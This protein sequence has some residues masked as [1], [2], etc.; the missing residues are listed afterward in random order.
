MTMEHA[1]DQHLERLPISALKLNP[2]N[3]RR[4][5]K[6]QIKQLARSIKSFG[7]RV[8]IIIDAENNVLSGHGRILALQL[9]GWTT[10]LVIRVS[11]L[12]PAEAA[13]FAIADNRLTEN[14]TWDDRLLG[15][16]F[17]DL[18]KLDLN[19]DLDVTGFSV[20]E[21]D[22]R[23]ESIAT[24]GVNQIDSADWLP[25]VPNHDPV[26]TSGDLWLLDKHRIFCGDS[27][28]PSSY[29]ALM[30]SAR[31][32]VVF[33]DPPYDVPISGHVSGNGRIHHR[34]F[35][36]AS[37]EMTSSQFTFFLSNVLHLLAQYSTRG[38]LHFLCMD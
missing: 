38:S 20:A 6:Q 3:P 16:I 25:Q 2:R 27:T 29:S 33:S 34:E 14:A 37:G 19:F 22:L 32:A 24:P 26:S 9:L 35:A 13:A 18:S 11:D 12:T 1:V 5:S 36:M 28:Q 10:V 17:S 30:Q 8:P 21:I 4:H 7:F 23:I 31:A 15:E